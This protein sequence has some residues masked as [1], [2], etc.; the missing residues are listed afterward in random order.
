MLSNIIMKKNHET[1]SGRTYAGE[2][3]AERQAKRH[4]KFMEAGHELFGTI[5]F[6][7]TTVRVICKQAE[8]TDRYFYE[9]FSSMEDVLVLVYEQAIREIQTKI[10][11][12][13]QNNDDQKYDVD[14]LIRQVLDIFFQA[15]E[16]PKTARII[17]LEVLGV[18]T[19][20]DIIYNN[21]IRSFAAL[22]L[23]LSLSLYPDIQLSEAER[24]VVAIG[25][26]GAISQ[27]TMAWLLD[28]YQLDRQIMVNSMFHIIKGT[29]SQL[30]SAQ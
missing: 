24:D 7:Q 6:R 22:F 27:S 17:W 3:Q 23:Q 26:V 16:C 1:Q 15:V 19:R 11:L 28:G 30:I 9:S 10:L 8:L 13:I 29:T 5:G 21:A 20:V 2:A 14:V 18:S 12:T 4:Q 25:I